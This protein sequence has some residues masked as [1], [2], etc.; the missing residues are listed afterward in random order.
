MK[1]SILC[2]LFLGILFS[3]S[4]QKVYFIYIQSENDQ[5]FFVRMNSKVLNSST[6]GYLILSSL[7]DSVYNF[8][9]GFPQS[10]ISEHNFSVTVNKKDHGYLL[11]NFGEKGWGLYDLQ[12]LSV[13]MPSSVIADATVKNE[14]NSSVFTD[15]LSKAADDQSLKEKITQPKLEEKKTDINTQETGKIKEEKTAQPKIEEK[16]QGITPKEDIKKEEEKLL[17]TEKQ[18]PQK[19]E[20]KVAIKE[21]EAEKSEDIKTTPPDIYKPTV[22]TKKSESSNV[23]GFGLVFIDDLGDDRKDT[24]R[25]LIPN[26]K[27]QPVAVKPEVKEEKKFLDIV[28]DTLN[29]AI[30][31]IPVITKD[32]A[33]QEKPILTQQA[34]M[35]SCIEVAIDSD[36]F[37]LRKKMVA[38]NTDAAMISEATKY[39]NTKCFTT[40]Q[41]KN[42]S[43]LFL[44]DEGKYKF[45]DAA[46][47]YISDVTNFSTLQSELKEDYYINRFKAMLR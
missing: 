10:K 39:F 44:T 31:I 11:K 26:L 20:S 18:L 3:A 29:R 13:Q 4:A 35:K 6:A 7:R 45:F 23:E 17:V 28:A 21:Q 33:L 16:Q 30:E 14:K 37:Q 40:L 24:I 42:L 27:A 38:E 32:S 36:F 46:Y 9:I 15:I 22:V 2:F 34:I 19:E 5:P 25:I 8:S 12:N 41:V 43:T 47:P 1:R